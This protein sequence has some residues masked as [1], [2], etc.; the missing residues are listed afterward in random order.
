MFA[1]SSFELTDN[2]AYFIHSLTHIH[3][4]TETLATK[5]F[6]SWNYFL[7]FTFFMQIA[8]SLTLCV[9]VC[10]CVDGG[11]DMFVRVALHRS[12]LHF[13]LWLIIHFML[14]N[15]V[16]LF[17][18]SLP[19]SRFTWIAVNVI[20][21]STLFHLSLSPL[22]VSHKHR[23]RYFKG[24]KVQ[25]DFDIKIEQVCMS[26]CVPPSSTCPVILFHLKAHCHCFP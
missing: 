13:T 2:V 25:V 14:I 16:Q 21:L 6:N 4:H 24:R 23:S 9:C 15:I 11:D 17:S 12:T 10:V 18:L 22:L 19:L 20:V 3:S 5:S 1:C 26:S 7:P 8:H